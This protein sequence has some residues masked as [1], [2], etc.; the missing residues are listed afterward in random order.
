M[1]GEGRAYLK[2]PNAVILNA[3][4]RRNTQ[5]NSNE[6]KRAPTQVNKRAQ[7]GAMERIGALPRK[8]CKQPGL[9]PNTSDFQSEVGEVFGEI[10]GELPAKFG[11]EIFELLLLGKI[12]RSIVHQSSTANFTIKLHYEVLGCGGPWKQPGVGT[13]KCK[14]FPRVTKS[15]E[16][17]V[18]VWL[19]LTTLV[20]FSAS[21]Q[22]VRP[23][24]H[25]PIIVPKGPGRI[26]TAMTY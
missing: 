18:R 8:N 19:I 3:V 11:R 20:R 13:P 9:K 6:R 12:V 26:K 22:R 15:K 10:V 24:R 21:S 1:E 7:K 5:E 25:A 2:L 17:I 16:R 4:G 23:H 14:W